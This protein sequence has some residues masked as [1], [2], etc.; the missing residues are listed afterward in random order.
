MLNFRGKIEYTGWKQLETKFERKLTRLTLQI[1]PMQSRRAGNEENAQPAAVFCSRRSLMS[2]HAQRKINPLCKLSSEHSRN[3]C[4]TPFWNNF[5]SSLPST[6]PKVVFLVQNLAEIKEIA[7][8]GQFWVL[9]PSRGPKLN[10]VGLQEGK[11]QEKTV[12]Y[13]CV[14]GAVGP[15]VPVAGAE[16]AAAGLLFDDADRG[17]R[18]R[19]PGG[20]VWAGQVERRRRRPP[21]ASCLSTRSP[22]TA[23]PWHLTPLNSLQILSTEPKIPSSEQLI[24]VHDISTRSLKLSSLEVLSTEH[25]HQFAHQFRD[26]KFIVQTL[27]M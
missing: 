24:F 20:G 13:L 22:R 9:G 8:Q 4:I 2:T 23:Q 1:L 14:D 25:K 21:R 3:K 19:Q 5:Q 11:I 7:S 15:Q 17:R 10:W 26:V 12:S 6:C 16:P 27:Y 18:R